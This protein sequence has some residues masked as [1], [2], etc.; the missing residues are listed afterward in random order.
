MKKF[1]VIL[2]LGLLWCNVGNASTYGRGEIKL[3]QNVVDDFI[4]YLRGKM[5]KSPLAFVITNDGTWGTYWTCHPGEKDW[6]CGDSPAKFIYECETKSEQECSI[7]ARR[8]TV[9]WKNGINKG[10]RESRF[11]SKWSDEEI[12]T[13]LF[14]LG[15]L[16]KEF[17][18]T[19]Y[20]NKKTKTTISST[21]SGITQELKELNDLYKEGGLTKEEFEKAKKK[22]LSQ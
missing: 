16:E 12:I 19:I 22:V 17:L 18:E 20:T 2:V 14:E 5:K 3:S 15:F 8:R 13:R 11:N 1:L 6:I 7:F 9:K 21:S 4:I 10:K